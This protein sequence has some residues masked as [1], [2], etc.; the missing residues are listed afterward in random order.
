[1]SN[2]NVVVI[3][4]RLTK[5]PEGKTV[6]GKTLAEFSIAVNHKNK[7]G[8]PKADF[9]DIKAW[10]KTGDHAMKWLKKGRQVVIEGHLKEEKWQDKSGGNR[11]K[12]II[13]ANRVTFFG[14][15]PDSAP[16]GGQQAEPAEFNEND[17][18][19]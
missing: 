14:D 17:I 5:D 16:G 15:K 9:F 6:G 7:D 12:V 8:E 19:F 13:V 3:S 18:P 11:S 4:G 2:V 10:D 1:M